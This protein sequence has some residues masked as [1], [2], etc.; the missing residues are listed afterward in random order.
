VDKPVVDTATGGTGW[1]KNCAIEGASNSGGIVGRM[2]FS[3]PLPT[4]PLLATPPPAIMPAGPIPP[5]GCIEEQKLGGHI[6]P[7]EVRIICEKQGEV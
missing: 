2:L 5:N 4:T 3:I 6:A 1:G 7:G